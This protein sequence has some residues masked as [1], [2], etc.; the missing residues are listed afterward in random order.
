MKTYRIYSYVQKGIRHGAGACE[1]TVLAGR[2]VLREGYAQTAAEDF[3]QAGVADGMGGMPAGDLASGEVMEQLSLL[4]PAGM[5][6]EDYGT[7]LQRLNTRIRRMGESCP[8]RLG[9]GST[10]ALF[11]SCLDGMFAAWAGNSRLYK[12]FGAGMV[13]LTVDHN[14]GREEA[15][16]LGT[17][18]E[19]AYLTAY[20]G[21]P[22]EAYSEKAQMRSV[23]AAE[24][25]AFLLTTDG[26]HDWLSYEE[27]LETVQD[28]PEPDRLLPLLARRARETGSEDDISIVLIRQKERAKE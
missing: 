19:G 7:E 8:E 1:D 20:M 16:G 23:R 13:A 5:T 2:T 14:V 4:D 6:M 25:D 18:R 27:M 3:F 9:M 10:L 24:E 12:I 11:C 22:E 17:S 21:M 28:V 26:L 15:W